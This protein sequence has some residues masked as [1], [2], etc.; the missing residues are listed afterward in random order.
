MLALLAI[1]GA[2]GAGIFVDSLARSADSDEAEDLPE[3]DMAEEATRGS[4]LDPDFGA[5]GTPAGFVDDGM[6]AS[7]DIA[8]PEAEPLDLAG[9]AGD[10]ILSGGA[11]GDRL[12]GGDGA[13]QLTGRGGDDRLWGGAGRDWLDGGDGDDSLYGQGGDDVLN[14]GAGDDVLVGGRGADQ[15]AG[16]PGDDR[17]WGGGGHDTLFG[18]EGH[19]TLDGGMGRDWLAGGSGNDLLIG[20]GGRDTLD[21][22]PGNDTLWGG[23]EGASDG[24]T[25]WLNGGAGDDLLGVGPGD[26]ATGGAGSDV[27]QL[28][29]FGPGLPVAD[30]MDYNPEE[31]QLVL[32][33]DATLHVAPVLSAEPVEGTGDVTLMLDGVAVALIRDAPDLDLSLI[34]LRA[35]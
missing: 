20:G 12:S 34:Q 15:L 26:I 32:L 1:M 6:P 10:D 29:D 9:G 4:L 28:Q 8:D 30:I 31:D 13:D 17:L 18:G 27:F 35:A 21:G 23:S 33:Y 25:D 5:A 3:D 14:G 2:L 11:A 7:D 24:A 19:D 22:G 16:G